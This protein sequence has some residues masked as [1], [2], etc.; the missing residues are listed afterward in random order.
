MQ[1][2][3]LKIGSTIEMEGSI[4]LVVERALR[5]QPR[6]AALIKAKLKNV[7]TGQVVEKRFGTTD[8]VEEAFINKKD[9]QYLYSDGNLYYFMDTE[10][11]EQ[12]PIDKETLGDSLKYLI[13]GMVASVS[14]YKDKIL[15]VNIPLF[16]DMKIVECEPAVAGD[17]AKNASKPATTETGLVVRVP[18]FVDNGETIKVDSRN[19]EYIERIKN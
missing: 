13:E 10:T 19:G 12:R 15:F 11:Y 4:Y 7:E 5:Q 18:L 9:M 14:I 16:V 17:T 1:A 2:N 3:D 6:L 8:R